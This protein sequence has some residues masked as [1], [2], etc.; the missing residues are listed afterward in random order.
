MSFSGGFSRWVLVGLLSD[1]LVVS[2]VFS[3]F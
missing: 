2:V 3:G 1:G